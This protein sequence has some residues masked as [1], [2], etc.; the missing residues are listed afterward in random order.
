MSAARG[1][2]RAE[3]W[4]VDVCGAADLTATARWRRRGAAGRAVPQCCC[5]GLRFTALPLQGQERMASWAG[6]LLARHGSCHHL[7]TSAS[8][9]A[10]DSSGQTFAFRT[11]HCE[12]G[13]CAQ[14]ALRELVGGALLLPGWLRQHLAGNLEG[15]CC[16]GAFLDVS[17]ALS[18]AG[19]FLTCVPYARL[20]ERLLMARVACAFCFLPIITIAAF[21]ARLAHSQVSW[22]L[23]SQ[24]PLPTPCACVVT[25]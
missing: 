25:M 17:A 5:A 13:P 24:E 10:A 21:S 6:W 12:H 19:P 14:D 4:G 2:R 23:L 1:P 22:H 18:A 9:L 20:P 16:L 7:C 15:S 3:R 8:F 11:L